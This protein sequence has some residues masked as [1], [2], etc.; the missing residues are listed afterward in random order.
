MEIRENIANFVSPI[1]LT[2]NKFILF[3]LC[4][5]TT[6]VSFAVNPSGT[7]PVLTIYTENGAAV[8]SRETYVRGT[9]SFDPMGDESM[10]SLF[11][12]LE[13]RGRGNWTWTDFEK[14]PYRIKL[15]E[16]AALAGMERSRHF[17]LLAHADDDLGFLRNAL[18][19][20]LSELMHVYWTP[21]MRPVELVLNGD[22]R[23]LYF[24]TETVRVA[25]K[26]VNVTDQEEQGVTS[27]PTGGWLCEIDNY[28]E[29]PSEQVVLRDPDGE[30]LRVT[31]KS[32]E[33]CNAEQQKFL[34]D[35]LTAMTNAIYINDKS[36]REW[37]RYIDPDAL[38]R[39]FV[40]RE[41]MDDVE[42]FWGSCYFSRE[43][44][45]DTKWK[46]GPV[47][48]FGY[49][50]RRDWPQHIYED[51]T[52]GQRWIHRL[53]RFDSFSKLYKETF[54]KFVNAHYNEVLDYISEFSARIAAGAR[55]DAERW[56]SEWYGNPDTSLTAA[57]VRRRF[58][59]RVGWLAESYGVEVAS[60]IAMPTGLYLR[61]DQND[62]GTQPSWE[63]LQVGEN[64]YE[65]EDVTLQGMFKVA[66]TEWGAQN[67]GTPNGRLNIYAETPM[68]LINGQDYN[69]M[70]LEQ[71]T[72]FA[73]VIFEVLEPGK[74]ARIT[75]TN[76]AGVESIGMEPAA[77]DRIY[78]IYG[79]E[80]KEMI[81]GN[82]YIV[83]GR[84][85]IR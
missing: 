16:K 11:G 73:R 19:F 60:N 8:N 70:I 41:L 66:D 5:V 35:Q 69:D 84:K 22:Y 53:V 44:G 74:R 46:F 34:V 30:D 79:H 33:K 62:W 76:K 45:Q 10:T 39:Y 31:H 3:L 81:P 54:R 56:A 42:A 78:D 28:Y 83:N 85:I 49:S 15:T 37:E 24:L 65:I 58:R 47:W 17:A 4:T 43:R 72:H 21:D 67:W 61:G 82:I 7:L 13:I 71:P 40:V 75:L 1:I 38:A 68:E 51:P 77:T 26:R 29:D 6:A 63:L 14:K 25:K 2:M 59:Q 52:W 18:G 48:D 27:D 57:E 9:Y 50:Y 23:G 64:R 20:K 12:T 32:P 80:V 36:S 55:A